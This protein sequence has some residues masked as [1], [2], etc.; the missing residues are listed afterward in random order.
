MEHWPFVWDLPSLHVR[1]TLRNPFKDSSLH[2]NFLNFFDP[3][4][5]RLLNNIKQV[6]NKQVIRSSTDAL[7]FHRLWK[8]SVQ[9]RG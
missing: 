3:E 2:M 6:I 1:D 4:V 8:L 7:T 9:S 5:S